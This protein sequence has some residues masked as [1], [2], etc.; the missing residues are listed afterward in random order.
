MFLAYIAAG[1]FG[2]IL[3]GMGMGGGTLLIPILS[4]ILGE[5]QRSAQAVNLISFVPVAIVALIIHLKNKMVETK[6]LWLIVLFGAAFAALGAWTA[7]AVGGESLKRI[8]GGFL[9]IL[10]TVCFFSV[11][12]KKKGKKG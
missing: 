9:T 8:F 4:V 10:S 1:F 5:A 12:R 11:F 7:K 6:G 3:G 2:G